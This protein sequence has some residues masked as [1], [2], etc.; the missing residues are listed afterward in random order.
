MIRN[1]QNLL[2][3]SKITELIRKFQFDK[4]AFSILTDNKNFD[5]TRLYLGAFHINSFNN[6][7]RN[8]KISEEIWLRNEDLPIGEGLYQLFMWFCKERG[9]GIERAIENLQMLGRVTW[10]ARQVNYVKSL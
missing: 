6:Y 3:E 1:R 7:K 8:S 2:R 5:Q 10:A 9:Y 4:Y